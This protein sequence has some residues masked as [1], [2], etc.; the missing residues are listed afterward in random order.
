MAVEES[1]GLWAIYFDLDDDGLA[2][3]VSQKK[4]LEI[5]LTRREKRK[6]KSED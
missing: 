5:T 2:D 3:K 4:L 1:P 6:K